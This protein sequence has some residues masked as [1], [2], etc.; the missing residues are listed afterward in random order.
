MITITA[1]DVKDFFA[2]L[3]AAFTIMI[4]AFLI[5]IVIVKLLHLDGKK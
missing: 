5:S 2:C 1:A 4:V 3:G